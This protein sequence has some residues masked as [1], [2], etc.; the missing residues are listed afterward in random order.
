MNKELPGK[1]YFAV[2]RDTTQAFL[3]MSPCSFLSLLFHISPGFACP[4]FQLSTY[5]GERKQKGAMHLFYLWHYGSKS[6][7]EA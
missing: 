2:K 5:Q 4:P 7:T 1:F 6:E 3:T